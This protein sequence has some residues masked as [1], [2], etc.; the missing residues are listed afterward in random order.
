MKAFIYDEGCAGAEIFFAETDEEGIN[1]HRAEQTRITLRYIDS[2]KQGQVER[3]N[4]RLIKNEE[5]LLEYI[6][7]DD[8]AD[9]VKIYDVVPG[10]RIITEGE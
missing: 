10:L 7:S 8:F 1:H 4:M 2:Y 6:K 5:Y 3:E 9:R